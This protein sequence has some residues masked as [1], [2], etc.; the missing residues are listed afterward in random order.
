MYA[1]PRSFLRRD[2]PKEKGKRRKLTTQIGKFAAWVT[3]E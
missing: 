3:I 2:L 1:C